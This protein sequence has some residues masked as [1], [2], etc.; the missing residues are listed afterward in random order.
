MCSLPFKKPL[1]FLAFFL[2][3]LKQE[4]VAYFFATLSPSFA[5]SQQRV[6]TGGQVRWPT[7]D[8][9]QGVSWRTPDTP[10]PWN[11]PETLTSSVWRPPDHRNGFTDPRSQQRHS[12]I[13][14][15][16]SRN[17]GWKDDTVDSQRERYP[18]V[19]DVNTKNVGIDSDSKALASERHPIFPDVI[20]RNSGWQPDSI[21]HQQQRHSVSDNLGS[22]A[23]DTNSRRA[24]P[25]RLS[26]SY[27]M[28]SGWQGGIKGS[29]SQSY[30][31]IVD[32]N[33]RNAA[34]VSENIPDSQTNSAIRNSSWHGRRQYIYGHTNPVN[35]QNSGWDGGVR[36]IELPRRPKLYDM[37]SKSVD[38]HSKELNEHVHPDIN[39]RNTSWEILTQPINIG[40]NSKNVEWHGDTKDSESQS[41]SLYIHRLPNVPSPDE[42]ESGRHIFDPEN[43]ATISETLGAINTLGKY[44]VNVTRTGE[45]LP[46]G[47]DPLRNQELPGALYTISKN[48]LGRNVTDTIAPIVRGAL[49]PLVILQ[50]GKVTLDEK[51]DDDDQGR[52]CTTPD[53]RKGS[54]DDLSNCPQLLLDLGNLRQSICF[55]SLFVPGVCC[56]RPTYVTPRPEVASTTTRRPPTTTRRPL[57]SLVVTSGAA[58]VITPGPTKRPTVAPS[59]ECGQP[60]VPAFRVVGG[61]E[62]LPGRWPWMAA[63]F[64]HGARRTEFWCGGSLVGPRH[65][66]TA[67]HC[68]R[69][70]KQRPFSPRQFTVRLGDVDLKRDDEPSS[71]E[72]FRVLEVRAHPRFSRVGFYNDIALM[73]LDHEYRH[74]RFVI[75]LCLPP[76]RSIS[77]TFVGQKPTVVGWG[78][79]Y[80]GGKESTVQ[81]QAQLPV[82]RNDDCDRTYFQPITSSFICAGY[83]EG[84]KDACQGDSGGP[85][86]LKQDAR[87][88]QIGIVS[89]GNKC[90]EPGYPGVYTRVTEYVDWIKENMVQ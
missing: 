8:G 35:S 68:T 54:C 75:P 2:R 59:E 61:E 72:T 50:P 85:L 69:D 84:G 16:T 11:S 82:W 28:S 64:L 30:P 40:T 5:Q 65:V 34:T 41:H 56:P 25:H 19:S 24:D 13:P 58:S 74:S 22:S 46:S 17:S 53:G 88:M 70:S 76:A 18:L 27:D 20:S 43:L 45:I 79:T 86:M 14:E 33:S 81:R 4:C 87:W 36:A 47:K 51:G 32:L 31:L 9:H 1:L 37:G 12:T 52:P 66:L 23:Q 55:K 6:T 77:E 44:L 67:A 48:V 90:G 71:P 7:H 49:P 62:S 89:F 83:T 42:V 15:I 78:T 3:T 73:V 39:S 26:T 63:I 21:S 57:P 80:Y 10:V 29:D 38:W 60:E